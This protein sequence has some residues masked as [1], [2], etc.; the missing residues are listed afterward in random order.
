M[1]EDYIELNGQDSK[2]DLDTR[3]FSD[4]GELWIA[5]RE[6]RSF[7]EGTRSFPKLSFR[8]WPPKYIQKLFWSFKLPSVCSGSR[9]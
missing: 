2:M 3:N 8:L 4:F 9:Q 5:Q 1:K 7:L 6:K